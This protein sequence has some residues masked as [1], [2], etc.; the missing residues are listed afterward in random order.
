MHLLS[1]RMH[2]LC[3]LGCPRARSSGHTSHKRLPGGF[4]SILPKSVQI[5]DFVKE[6]SFVLRKHTFS[7]FDNRGLRFCRAEG[8]VVARYPFN[9]SAWPADSAID[10]AM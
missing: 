9:A 3:I 10:Q 2:V 6:N 7:K 1:D 5:F 4:P 8:V